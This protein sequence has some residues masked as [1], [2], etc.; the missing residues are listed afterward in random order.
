MKSRRKFIKFIFALSS[1]LLICFSSLGRG[2]RAAWAAA[3][4]RLIE[5]GT[6]MTELIY[7]RPR[8]IDTSE[9]ETTPLDEFDVMG[10]TTFNVDLAEWRLEIDGGVKLPRSFS[11][12]ELL[13]RPVIETNGLLICPGFF[14]YNGLW[15]GFSIAALLEELGIDKE[16]RKVKFS[17]ST[18]LSRQSKRYDIEE[19]MSDRVFIAYGV[20]GQ[21]LPQSHGFPMRVVAHD[22]RGGRWVKYLNRVTVIV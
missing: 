17:G 9:L 14:A 16:A 20:N 22:H 4:R 7:A 21:P 19:V 5:R 11:Y 12:D 3:T 2:V 15:K 6:P 10:E 1:W 13:T 18:G 8:K